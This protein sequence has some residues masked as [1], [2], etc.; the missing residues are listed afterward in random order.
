MQIAEG[1]RQGAFE[2]S[3]YFADMGRVILLG[4]TFYG[5]PDCCAAR[6]PTQ[7]AGRYFSNFQWRTALSVT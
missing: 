1:I 5:R 7:A 2:R 6:V 3:I 4:M